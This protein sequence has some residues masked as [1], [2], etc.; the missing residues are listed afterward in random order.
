MNHWIT[1]LRHGETQANKATV[2]QG[3]IDSPLSTTGRQQAQQVGEQWRK[4]GVHFDHVISSPLQR[5]R[6]TAQIVT[7]VLGY[8]G[9]IELNPLWLERSFGDLEGKTISQISQMQPSVD[10]FQAFVPIGGNG[11][12]QLDL[13]LRAAQ[14]LQQLVRCESQNILVVSHGA[15]I[16]MALFS[17][18]GI[19]P[20]GHNQS[21]VFRLGNTAYI[22]LNYR[23]AERQW[24]FFGIRNP[25][26]WNGMEPKDDA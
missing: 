9:E 22:N 25:N 13:Y 26:E 24:E 23:E 14:A 16:G 17:V 6:E 4:V 11:E 7:Q 21:L 1:L 18:L 10:F 3:Q 15:L 19:T 5:A 12:S 8:N 2:L 20:Q